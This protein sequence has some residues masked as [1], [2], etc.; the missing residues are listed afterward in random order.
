MLHAGA[1]HKIIIKAH[2]IKVSLLT[3][4][5]LL[6]TVRSS[7]FGDDDD[8]DELFTSLVSTS[9]FVTPHSSKSVKSSAAKDTARTQDKTD[10]TDRPVLEVRKCS[11]L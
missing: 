7:I 6:S 2:K 11:F 9:R 10:T 5:C 4:D 3:C 8:D 1:V